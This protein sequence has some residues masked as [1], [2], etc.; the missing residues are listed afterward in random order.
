M[1]TVITAG[2]RKAVGKD[3]AFEVFAKRLA[4]VGAWCVVITLAVELACAGELKPGLEVLGYR[5]VEQGCSGRV[6]TLRGRIDNLF[7]KSYWSS[8]GGYPGANYL[9]LAKPRTFVLTGTVNF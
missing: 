9:V 6:L 7:N 8:A 1:T 5:A 2:P 4:D 3:A